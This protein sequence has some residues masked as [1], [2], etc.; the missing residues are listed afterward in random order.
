MTCKKCGSGEV[1]VTSDTLPGLLEELDDVIAR[2]RAAGLPVGALERARKSL[3]N[4]REE[5]FV[6]RN[7]RVL[8]EAREKFE[9]THNI[10]RRIRG[11]QRSTAPTT[12]LR[13]D[14]ASL[15]TRLT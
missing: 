3:P 15:S 5:S 1:P 11:G 8:A 14:R 13:T 10:L 9:N 7:R 2:I 12:P 4:L 6:E